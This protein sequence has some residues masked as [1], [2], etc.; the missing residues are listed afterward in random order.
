[1]GGGQDLGERNSFGE[2][3]GRGRPSRGGLAA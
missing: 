3:A 1:M 2:R